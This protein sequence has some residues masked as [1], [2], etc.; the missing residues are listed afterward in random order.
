MSEKEEE[1]VRVVEELVDRT[2]AGSLRKSG[3]SG[4][5]SDTKAHSCSSSVMNL[6]WWSH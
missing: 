2:V 3:S 4:K 6:S 1:L 5:T